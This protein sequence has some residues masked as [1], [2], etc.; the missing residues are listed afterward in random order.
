MD[1]T[2]DA[3]AGY[4]APMAAPPL[5]TTPTVLDRA[6]FAREAEAVARDLVGATLAVAGADGVRRVRIVETEAYVGPH[7]LACHA[8]R[9][10]TA[11]TAVMF[12]PPGFAYVYLIYGLHHL[13]NVVTGSEGDA[14][15][16]LLRAA[17]VVG[18]APGIAPAIAS[19]I[20]SSI[21]P[22]VEPCRGPG[23]LT[24]HLGID[25]LDNG[26]DVCPAPSS[27]DA[28]I[29]FEAGHPPGRL[30]VSPRIGVDY[31]GAWA[32]APLR[33]FDAGSRAVSRGRRTAVGDRSARAADGSP[34]R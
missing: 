30:A 6:S 15:A 7:D 2:A 17:E 1:R 10:R 13:L 27:G 23:R 12:G 19:S 21:A 5:P 3:W 31:A 34:T 28:R 32:A 33:F 14:Q 18:M 29:W 16:V 8:A 22:G 9:G 24:R 4:H 11:R 20:A 25:R 26:R